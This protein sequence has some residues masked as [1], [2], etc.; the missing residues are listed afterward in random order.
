WML[1]YDE[2][3]NTLRADVRGVPRADG[4]ERDGV[5]LARGLRGGVQRGDFAGVLRGVCG[6]VAAGALW[7]VHERVRWAGERA[8]A[9]DGRGGWGVRRGV[10]QREHCV[11]GGLPRGVGG[12]EHGPVRG[13]GWVWGVRVAGRER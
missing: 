9:R 7:V 8:G 2:R 1:R 10:R 6:S 3:R 12:A 13:G 11:Q 5:V 4:G